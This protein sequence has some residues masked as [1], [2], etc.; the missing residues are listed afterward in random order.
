MV[1]FVFSSLTGFEPKTLRVIVE[2]LPLYHYTKFPYKKTRIVHNFCSRSNFGMKFSEFYEKA[3]NLPAFGR[4]LH[5]KVVLDIFKKFSFNFLLIFL[6]FTV[7]STTGSIP[8]HHKFTET[9]FT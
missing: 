3:H 9:H 1:N 8:Q 5:E 6:T 4:I 2:S 7:A